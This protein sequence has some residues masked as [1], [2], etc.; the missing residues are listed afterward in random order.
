MEDMTQQLIWTDKQKLWLDGL[1]AG[2]DARF[3]KLEKE[4]ENLKHILKIDEDDKI[5][6]FWY[7]EEVVVKKDLDNFNWF[8]GGHPFSWGKSH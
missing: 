7:F 1:V 6:V 3:E 4:I 2:Y 8:Y 5:D